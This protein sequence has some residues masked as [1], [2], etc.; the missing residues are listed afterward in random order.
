MGSPPS[1]S[2]VQACEYVYGCLHPTM[3]TGG[4]RKPEKD[5][6]IFLYLYP[7]TVNESLLLNWKL[8]VLAGSLP[9]ELLWSVCLCPCTNLNVGVKDQWRH[10]YLFIWVLGTKLRSLCLHKQVLLPILWAIFLASEM[11]FKSRNCLFLFCYVWVFCLNDFLHHM[12]AVP[13]EARRRH[14]T[15]EIV[16]SDGYMRYVP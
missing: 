14:Q 13:T 1:L 8:A 5:I 4:Q 10:A 6:C 15:P 11:R 2:V 12:C 3:F 7:I 16:V 9:S